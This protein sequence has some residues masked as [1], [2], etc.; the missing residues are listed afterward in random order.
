MK[1]ITLHYSEDLIRRAVTAYW[2]RL[3]GWRYWIALALS[4]SSLIYLIATGD[5]SWIV[6]VF[7]SGLALGIIFPVAIYFYQYNASLSRYRRMHNPEATF[8]PGEA[9]FR[10]TSDV[11]SSNLSWSTIREIRR[12]PDFWMVFFSQSQFVILPLVDL[13]SETRDWILAHVKPHGTKIA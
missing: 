2:L 1:S 4:L 13:D 10:M 8:K 11:G 3:T 5:R 9:S 7:G 12:F 6:G